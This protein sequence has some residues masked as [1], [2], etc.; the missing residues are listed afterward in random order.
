MTKQ[1]AHYAGTKVIKATPMTLGEFREYANQTQLPTSRD[2]K[3]EGYLIEYEP[4]EGKQ[5][6]LDGHKGYV[7]WTPKQVFD[8][9]YY[10]VDGMPFGIALEL[11][12]KGYAVKRK[13]TRSGITL[14]NGRITFAHVDVPYNLSEEA[15]LA[16]DWIIVEKE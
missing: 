6:N 2:T 14:N 15:I 12:R 16:T 7:S 4:I 3:T 10:N 8:N 13:G 11:M 9:S 1:Y 5:S